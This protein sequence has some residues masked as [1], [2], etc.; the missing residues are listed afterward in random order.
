MLVAGHRRPLR[1]IVETAPKWIAEEILSA[2]ERT[3]DD[4]A[5]LWLGENWALPRATLGLVQPGL[6]GLCT[7][8]RIQRQPHNPP[9]PQFD[10][11]TKL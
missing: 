6:W 8:P 1:A 11:H 10:I 5:V 2:N 7:I 3:G 4:R 9:T